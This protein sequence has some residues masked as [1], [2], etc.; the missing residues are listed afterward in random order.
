MSILIKEQTAIVMID[1][2]VGFLNLF[3][4]HQVAEHVNA[5]VALAKTGKIYDVPLI[6]TNGADTD[7][8]GPLVAPLKETLGDTEVIVRGGNFNAFDTPDFARAVEESGRRTL[9]VSGLMTEG[10]VAQTALAALDRGFEVY[11]V[12]DAVAGET[13]ETH[14]AAIQRLV[15]AGAKPIT[16]LAAASEFQGSYAN[17]ETV[18]QF[19]GLM[20]EHSPALG[21]MLQHSAARE[22]LAATA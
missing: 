21:A 2:A 19:V 16:W 15:A 20:M 17:L 8:P 18:Q 10:C 5:A 9:L 1:H 12:V 3:R 13:A 6:V 4:S 14:E 7:G 22:A 11:I